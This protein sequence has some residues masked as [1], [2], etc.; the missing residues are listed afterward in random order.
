M[1]VRSEN[2]DTCLYWKAMITNFF[3]HEYEDTMGVFFEAE[4][5]SQCFH[6]DG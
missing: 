5:F 2:T 3:T 6:E 1:M 4:Y